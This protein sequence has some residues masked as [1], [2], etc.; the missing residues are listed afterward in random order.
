MKSLL[1]E[2]LS[3]GVR[4]GAHSLKQTRIMKEEDKKQ[5]RDQVD[6]VLNELERNNANYSMVL[7]NRMNRQ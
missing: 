5:Y 1:M 6:G 2:D 3:N 4:E 7:Q